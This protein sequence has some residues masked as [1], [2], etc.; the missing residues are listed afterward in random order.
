MA[1]KTWPL[2][3]RLRAFQKRVRRKILGAKKV[4]GDWRRVHNEELRNLYS[5]SNVIRVIK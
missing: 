3:R 1:D 2:E 4:T 5:S